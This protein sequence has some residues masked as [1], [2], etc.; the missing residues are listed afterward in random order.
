M[1]VFQAVAF[2]AIDTVN[3]WECSLVCVTVYY[4][5][6]AFTVIIEMWSLSTYAN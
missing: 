2:L 6:H 3:R 5:V 4:Y 1:K